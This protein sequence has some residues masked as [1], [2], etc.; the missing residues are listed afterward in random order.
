[1]L[2]DTAPAQISEVAME[3]HLVIRNFGPI[4]EAEIEVRDLTIF[5]GP[6]ATGK[7]LAAQALYFLRGIEDVISSC[8]TVFLDEL[9]TA[10]SAL[11]WW[12]GNPLRVYVGSGS[13]LCWNSIQPSGEATHEIWWDQ[14]GMHLNEALQ[15]R[16]RR[17]SDAV[18]PQGNSEKMSWD[19][20]EQV[21]IP[22]G[23]T[24]YS[25]LPP[26]LRLFQQRAQRWPGCILAFYETLGT[27]MEQLGQ[28]RPTSLDMGPP[29]RSS[30]TD[31][32]QRRID[33]IIKGQIQYGPD[34]VFLRVGQKQLRSAT[35]AAGQM[36]TW[37]F[38]A[39]VEAGLIPDTQMYFEEPEAH[40]HPS[41]QHNVMEIVAYLVRRDTRF[42]LT[43]HSP[44]IL[45]AVN[46]F[47]MAQKVLDAGKSLP[48]DTSPEIALRPKQVAAYSFSSDGRVHDIM[49]I[50]VGL[51]DEDELDR[52]AD[53]LGAAFT[54]LQERLENVE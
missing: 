26:F 47:L 50:E 54:R 12:F 32:V 49:D 1:M 16:V 33:A 40:L 10:K 28:K 3:E 19:V 34:T 27:A 11:S 15:S 8:M 52:V 24:L 39:I 38:W 9:Q 42:L 29:G 6:Q 17:Y 4:Q 2:G 21:Y 51:I 43:T 25:F 48:A 7:S 36:E 13:R 53:E 22:A 44:Y 30:E 41:A 37:P 31:F 20:P 45:Y 23:R 5:V 18:R 46:N 14:D 35:I